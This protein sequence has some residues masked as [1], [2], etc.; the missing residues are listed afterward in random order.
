MGRLKSLPARLAAPPRLIGYAT[1]LDAERGR[2]KARRQGD[3]LRRL[4]NTKRWQDLRLVILERD[5]GTCRATGILLTG[6]CLAPN[7]AVID[8]IQPHRGNLM[9]FWDTDNLQAV[10]KSWHDTEKQK[11][12][13][14]LPG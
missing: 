9:L 12:E 3:N 13:R 5:D 6:K 1:R 7:S 11:I 4:Y 10:C 14:A 8:H 2:D